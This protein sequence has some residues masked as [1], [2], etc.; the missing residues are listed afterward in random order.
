M[1]KKILIANRGEIACRVIKT[2]RRMGITS[3]LEATPSI[4]LGTSEVTLLELT[5]AYAV[6]A[7]RGSGVWPY[8]IEEIREASGRVLYRRSGDGPGLDVERG[9]RAYDGFCTGQGHRR[10]LRIWT[11]AP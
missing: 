9:Q 11:A 6:F 7:N 4:A 1:F 5:S 10:L 3:D 8:A 2:A